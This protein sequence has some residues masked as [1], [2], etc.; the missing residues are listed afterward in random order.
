MELTMYNA[1][2]FKVKLHNG[3]DAYIEDQEHCALIS[4]GSSDGFIAGEYYFKSDI[5]DAI[6]FQVWDREYKGPKG[7]FGVVTEY[8]HDYGKT[9]S[10]YNIPTLESRYQKAAALIGKPVEY[11]KRIDADGPR[12]ESSVP[13]CDCILK[14]C[15]ALTHCHFVEKWWEKNDCKEELK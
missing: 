11:L 10:N 13:V 14:D 8:S 12:C 4:I 2:A 15:N 9:W 6:T 7:F 1:N 5:S 3:E